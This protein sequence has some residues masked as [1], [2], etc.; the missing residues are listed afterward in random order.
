MFVPHAPQS[1]VTG[2]C[3][4]DAGFTLVGNTCVSSRPLPTVLRETFDN[5]LSSANWSM[6]VGGQA[7]TKTICGTISAGGAAVF[8]GTGH[9]RESDVR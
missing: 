7:T 5:E 3:V 4:C 9:V 6:V 1:P 2:T 8:T